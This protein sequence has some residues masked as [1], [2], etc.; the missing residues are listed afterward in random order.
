MATTNNLRV[1]PWCYFV[2][3]N[4]LV[5][6]LVCVGAVRWE[7]F[8]LRMMAESFSATYLVLLTVFG[9][10]APFSVSKRVLPALAGIA[11]VVIT[12]RFVLVDQFAAWFESAIWYLPVTS[13]VCGGM[14][15]ANWR[16]DAR[17]SPLPKQ[18][19]SIRALMI[20]T[21]VVAATFPTL[22]LMIQTRRSGNLQ[23]MLWLSDALVMVVPVVLIAMG[24]LWSM[25]TN[26]LLHL[27]IVILVSPVF[28]MLICR[29]YGWDD[30]STMVRLTTTVAVL[31]T[32]LAWYMR[33]QKFQL[34][35]ARVVADE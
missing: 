35:R 28:G 30:F 11:L 17:T 5:F 12:G 20:G 16:V 22:N 24:I 19:F 6:S 1:L 14:Y 32:L 7:S 4:V 2:G 27:A 29:I 31:T 13:I 3:V 26:K 34:T 21:A 8:E 15:L 18:T 33:D 10:L 23:Q 9:W 25:L